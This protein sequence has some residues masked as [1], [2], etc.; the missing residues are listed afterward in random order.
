ML[1]AVGLA[2][3]ACAQVLI[4]QNGALA[5]YSA[6]SRTCELMIGSLLA[7]RAVGGA[8]VLAAPVR[9]M[10]GAA[11]LAAIV[12]A[13]L[14]LRS[15]SPF[16]GVT[17]LWPCLRAAALIEAGRGEGSAVSRWLSAR[18]L[19]WIGA[20]SF[21]LYLWHWPLLVFARHLLLGQPDALQAGLAVLGA[22]GLAW[23]SLRWVETPVRRAAWPERSFLIAGVAAIGACLLVAVGLSLA[24]RQAG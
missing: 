18:P 22:V 17:S 9:Q 15:D 24:A 21:S 2:S 4:G 8:A 10:L 1:A 12:S 6:L 5:F 23:A 14:L 20:L 16:P 11:G 19:R 3:L 7:V 13:C